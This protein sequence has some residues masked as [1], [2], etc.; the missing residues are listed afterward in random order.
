MST[1]E[2]SRHRVDLT[3]SIPP[4]PPELQACFARTLATLARQQN[5]D[6]LV[7]TST[8]GGTDE[9]RRIGAEWLTPRFGEALDP[10]RVLLTNGTQSALVLLLQHLVRP[11]RVVLAERLTYGV[12]PEVARVAGVKVVGVDIDSDGLIP[13]AADEMCQVHDV[14][15]IYCNPTF[16]NPTTSTMPLARRHALARVARKHRIFLIEDDP[17]G[18][19]Y[20]NLPPPLAALAPD[21]TWHLCGLT[22]CIA[23]A[24]R[25]AHVV[26]PDA[27]SAQKF[28]GSHARLTHWVAAPLVASFVIELI[29]SGQAADIA[30]WIATENT[31]RERL[32]RQILGCHGAVT[33]PRSPHAWLPLPPSMTQ[34]EIVTTLESRDVLVR[35]AKLFA[36]DDHPAPEAIRLSLSSPLQRAD[37]ER[38]LSTIASVIQSRDVTK[39]SR[40]PDEV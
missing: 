19:L 39:P 9:D 29:R 1:Q 31:A 8:P 36:V 22:K 40:R 14:G 18:R 10:Q 5:L 6:V 16:H 37:V 2:S 4:V 34:Q 24:M 30:Q 32:V 35:S 21:V 12:L 23:Q 11:G 38:A 7:R 13:E 15:A 27:A 26:A 3:R 33:Q 17:I 20:D 28:I 25:L